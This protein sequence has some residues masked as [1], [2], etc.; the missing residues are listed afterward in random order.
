MKTTLFYAL[1]FAATAFLSCEKDSEKKATPSTP[2]VLDLPLKSAELISQSNSFGI[3]LFK[4]T[5]Q[6]QDENLM[7]SPLSASTALTMLLNGCAGQT[8]QQ[9]HQMLGYTTLETGE[10]N[11]IYNVLVD[12]LIHADGNVK[13]A[14]ANAVW[15]RQN[16]LF[17]V[18][19]LDT[20]RTSFS[21]RVEELD[22]SSPQALTTINGWASDNTFGK[23]PQVLSEI[24]P[25]AVMFLMNALYFKGSW[26]YQFNT[27]LTRDMPFFPETGDAVNVPTMSGKMPVVTYAAN[28][29]T[30]LELPYGRGNFS[31]LFL[32][33]TEGTLT[34]FIEGFQMEDWNSMTQYFESASVLDTIEIS[35]PKF[36]FSYE[37]VLNDQLQSMGMTD[38]FNPAVANLSGITDESV[39]VSFVKQN[40]Y[41]EVN[42]VGTE[43]AAVTTIGIELTSMP[44][45]FYANK[46]FVFVIREK[47]S[48]T[49]LFIGKVLLPETE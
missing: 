27:Q 47:T 36:K 13:L 46:P 12:Q 3:D 44:N 48:N 4:K 24:S 26:K 18:P 19:F 15:Y 16:I 45:S 34:D 21:A 33:P 10:A 8:Y 35:I 37:K 20:M 9:I 17:K 14:L 41:I 30:A 1:V 42:E 32:L 29:F 28:N 43:A 39:F 22:F 38:A 11:H 7:L 5:S 23:I 6:V 31:M 40:T 49:I 2:A 25:D